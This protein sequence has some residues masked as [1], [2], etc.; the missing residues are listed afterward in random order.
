MKPPP[1]DGNLNVMGDTMTVLQKSVFWPL[2]LPVPTVMVIILVGSMVF[3]P[4]W[5]ET[6]ARDNAVRAGEQTV[7]QFKTLRGYYTKSVIKKTIANGKPL[8]PS[9]NHKT[10]KDGI[11]LPATF[12]HDMSELLKEEETSIALYSGYPFPNRSERQL[13]EFQAAAWTYLVENPEK[14]FSRQEVR[15]GNPVVRVAVADVMVADACVN[16]HNTIAGS[17][18]TDWKLVDVRGVPEVSSDI[19]VTVAAGSKLSTT[20]VLA[21]IVAGAVLIALVV[22]GARRVTRPLD[23]MNQVMNRLADGDTAIEIPSMGRSDEIGRMAQSV[24]VFKTNAAEVARMQSEERDREARMMQERRQARSQLADEFEG[25]VLNVV[26]NVASATVQMRDSSEL[27]VN[28]AGQTSDQTSLA[29]TNTE[30]AVGNIE[31]VAS[32]ATEL[33]ASVDEIARQV[34]HSTGV[35]DQAVNQA[36]QTNNTVQGLSEAVQRIGEVVNLIT[37]IAEQTNLLALNATIEAARAGDAG[38]GFAVVAAEVK[39]LATQ[40]AS[41]T[42]EIRTHIESVQAATGDAVGAI[43]GIGATIGEINEISANVASAV[44]EQRAAT[45]EI[46]QSIEQAVT[47]AQGVLGNIS[48]VSATAEETGRAAREVLTAS[49]ELSENSGKLR[50]E[51]TNF[52]AQIRDSGQTTGTG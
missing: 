36:S 7:Q 40:T 44:E 42:E 33:S 50:T 13:D 38:K 49:S 45:Q 43:D 30:S 27:M 17:P 8:K 47:G 35:A 16:C 46:A 22:Y 26:E 24:Q 18:K 21:I 51:V 2:V 41:A 12:I 34:K 11:P 32:A 6:N 48:E 29:S 25:A 4:R 20:I 3:I 19:G 52:I 39:S 1:S 5:V 23:D 10:M 28:A 14:T 15:D 37:D 31:T 9:Y